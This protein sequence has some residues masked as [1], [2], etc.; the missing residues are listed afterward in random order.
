MHVATL[1]IASQIRILSTPHRG[2][3]CVHRKNQMSRPMLYWRALPF[4][5]P[6]HPSAA[7]GYLGL[8]KKQLQSLLKNRSL[9]P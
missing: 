4:Q 9:F 1:K 2:I 3:Y 5:H 7:T 8:V 6:N